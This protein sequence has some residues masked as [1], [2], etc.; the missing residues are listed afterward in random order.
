MN[1]F[2]DELD[3]VE[4]KKRR[5]KED[6]VVT[7]LESQ[8]KSINKIFE[9]IKVAKLEDIYTKMNQFDI[10]YQRLEESTKCLK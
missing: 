8:A 2:T 10:L 9:A 7:L 1:A 3:K 5:T 4:L 6:R